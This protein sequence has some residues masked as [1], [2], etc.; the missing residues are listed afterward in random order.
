MILKRFAFVTLGAAVFFVS[1]SDD[2]PSTAPLLRLFGSTLT[3]DAERPNPVTTA[4]T[5][6]ANITVIDTNVVRVETFVSS[7]DS[8]TQA[9]IHAGDAETA[10][11]IMVFLAGTYPATQ[12]SVARGAGNAVTLNGVLSHVNITRGVTFF[13]GA[14]TFD[15]LLTRINNGTAYVNVHTRRN[16]AGEIRGQIAPK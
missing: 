7:I 11:P 9:H 3:G 8:V 14:F 16:P 5:G 1:C 12:Q 6:T 2:V 15:S 13:Q 10:G 4:A